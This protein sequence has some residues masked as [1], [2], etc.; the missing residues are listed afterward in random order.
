MSNCKGIKGAAPD[1]NSKTSMNWY[2]EMYGGLIP[3]QIITYGDLM[4]AA[5]SCN[6][7]FTKHIAWVYSSPFAFTFYFSNGVI[8]ESGLLNTYKAAVGTE[9]HLSENIRNLIPFKDPRI[10][11]SFPDFKA[12]SGKMF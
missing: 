10:S 12:P 6:I 9:L 2:S 5:V 7:D 11:L 1:H 4:D 3:Q 8:I